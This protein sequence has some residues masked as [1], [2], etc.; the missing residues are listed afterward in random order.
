MKRAFVGFACLAVL[1]VVFLMFAVTNGTAQIP[2]PVDGARP[3]PTAIAPPAEGPSEPESPESPEVDLPDLVVT[4]IEVVP[5]IPLKGQ[6][7]TIRVTIKNQGAADVQ[8]DPPNNFWSDLYVDPAELPIQ[9][10]QNGVFE[11]GCQAVWLPAGDSHVL[12]TEYVFHQVK[13]YALYAQ[14]DTDNHVFESNDYNNVGGPVMVEVLADALVQQTH[15]EF[16]LGM[17]SSLDISHPQGVIRRGIFWEPSTEPEVYYPDAQIDH[18]PPPSGPTNVNQER[19]A[20]IGDGASRV[21]AAWED[22]RDGGVFN[23]DIYLSRSFN[24]GATWLTPDVRI[25][26]DA[27]TTN[28]IRPALAYDQDSERLYA[29]WQDGRNSLDELNQTYDIYFAYS[30][31]YGATW[32]TNQMLNDDGGS[33][34][35]QNPSIA[36]GPSGEV[37]VVWQDERNNNADI[38]L[39]RSDN[40]GTTWTPNYFVTDDPDMTQ[41]N[42]SSPAVAVEYTGGRVVVAWEDWRDPVHP[43]IY[44]MWSW[45]GGQNFGIDVPVTIVPPEARTTYRRDPTLAIQTTTET[46]EYWDEVDEITKTLETDVTAI[47]LAWTDGQGDDTD[48]YYAYANYMWDPEAREPC[49]YPHDWD[50]CFKGPQKVNG[51]V[52]DSDYVLPSDAPPAWPIEPSWQGQASLALV[53]ENTHWTGCNFGSTEIYSRGVVIAWSDARTFDDWRYEIRTRRIAS[54]QGDPRQFDL[55]E[56][57]ATGHVNGNAKLYALRDDP[58]KYETYKPAATGKKNPAVFV[59]GSGIYVAWDDNRFDDP[60]VTGTGRDRDVFFARMGSEAQ[61]IYISPVLHGKSDAPMWYVLSWRGVTE[62][63]G[64]ILFQTRFGTNPN[65]PKTGTAGGGWTAWTGNPGSPSAVGCSA[66]ANCFY[67]A[68]GR[69]IVDP[70][71]DDWFDCEG[72]SCPGPYPYMQYKVILT[73]SS[74]RTAVSRVTVFYQGDGFTVFLPVVLR[75][76]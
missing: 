70:S 21:F 32:S 5:E 13:T 64:D 39:V 54:P 29:A 63:A 55:C 75:S 43:E 15:E 45:N 27:T 3:T 28:Q 30:D 20:V 74:R 9:L 62:H 60:T 37:Y 52:I 22:G 47:H 41:Q 69:H 68:P 1:V 38:Y 67:D 2:G 66:G 23:R 36:V 49:P 7:V 10:G 40:G 14:V 25:N 53:P 17:A 42:Q 35:Q 26:D 19:P 72:A 51:F 46:V 71:G 8:V 24:G 12:E 48:V 33:A 6:T 57:Y 61:G 18:P 59:N 56:D 73:G 4:S 11:W 65:P 76:Y 44:A 31:D 50:F 16:Q 58:A 34:N